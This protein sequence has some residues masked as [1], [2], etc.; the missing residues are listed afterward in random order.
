MIMAQKVFIANTAEMLSDIRITILWVQR[1]LIQLEL[2]FCATILRVE[3]L[4]G[5]SVSKYTGRCVATR[6]HRGP[7]GPIAPRSQGYY[8]L[9]RCLWL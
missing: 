1:N 9:Y 5:N 7:R 2:C 6:I 3:N 8:R 4:L